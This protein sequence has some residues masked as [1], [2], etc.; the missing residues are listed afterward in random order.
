MLIDK[1]K[2]IEV[3]EIIKILKKFSEE[4]KKKL[5]YLI[6]DFKYHL[7]IEKSDDLE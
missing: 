5:F 3:E 6:K 7:R 4:D 2:R 1:E